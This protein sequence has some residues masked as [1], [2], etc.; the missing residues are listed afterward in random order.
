MHTARGSK[1]LMR[2]INRALILNRIKTSRAISRADLA[3]QTGLSPATVTGIT[4]ELIE[5]DL[6]YEQAAGDSS[7]GRPPILLAINPDGGFVVGIKLADKFAVGALA[8][9][10]AVIH[11][12][13]T[14]ALDARDAASVVSKLVELVE[15]LLQTAGIRRERLKGI[16]IGVAGVV[17]HQAGVLRL[18]PFFGWKDIPLQQMIQNRLDVPVSIDNDVNTLTLFEKLFGNEEARDF[19]TITVGRGIGM[20]MVVNGQLYRGARGGAGELGH[21]VVDPEGPV[22]SCGKSGCLETYLSEP[23]LVSAAHAYNL[24]LDGRPVESVEDLLALERSGDQA[25]ARIFADA[26]ELLGR[27]AAMLVN[28]FEP[29]II[30]FSGEGTR[31][32]RT[33]FDALEHSLRLHSMPGLAQDAQIR[34]DEW[35][36][37]AWARGAAGLALQELFESPLSDN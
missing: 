10:N 5:E 8:D 11:E 37:D 16:G 24:M 34:I 29:E 19:L 21:S 4:A 23:A 28:V 9:L 1:D 36:D 7:G 30:I 15:Q 32:G 14:L 33:F 3:R 35:G 12:R 27:Y 2:A 25:A 17:D 31:Y 20:G 18:S 26:A 6:V 13:I 22:C